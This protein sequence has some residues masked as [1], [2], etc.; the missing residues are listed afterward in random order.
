MESY[1]WGKQFVISDPLSLPTPTEKIFTY[2][3]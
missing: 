3:N 2:D 1:V